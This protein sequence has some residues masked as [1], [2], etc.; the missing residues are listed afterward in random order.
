MTEQTFQEYCNR[1][2]QLE[3]RV[4]A[5][6]Q[7]P[8]EFEEIDFV[9]EHKKIPVTLDLTPCD[10]V[11]SRERALEPYKDLNDD[12]VISV[13]MI[14]K[15]INALPSVTTMRDATPEE[16]KSVN[17]YIKSISTPTG[18]KFSDAVSREAVI[19]ATH[20]CGDLQEVRGV[21]QQLPSVNPQPSEH[22]I[23][24]VHAM[25][26]R[27]GYKDAQKQKSGKWNEYYTS[28]KGNNVFNCKECG[29]TFVVT[30]GKD[31][32]NFCPNCGAKMESEGRN[33][34]N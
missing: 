9:Q 19:E 22:F 6:E 3:K 25:G 20:H 10:D 13:W 21:V 34:V 4:K 15:N 8:V 33:E 26:Y 23:D 5:L 28:Q 7:E 12:D 29:H 16:Q 1:V 24:G 11:I 32:M 31:N 17:D 14:K 2:H 18:V 30:Q 27:E